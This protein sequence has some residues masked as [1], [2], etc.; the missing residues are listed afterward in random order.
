MQKAGLQ[1][2]RLGNQFAGLAGQ[3]AGVHPIVGNL[4]GVL[5]NF[6]V[7]AGLTVGVL[8]G[9]AAIALAYDALTKSA[10]EA[11]KAQDEAVKSLSEMLK[12]RAG[13]PSGGIAAQ[14][15]QAHAKEPRLMKREAELLR[16]LETNRGIPGLEQ[17]T[18]GKLEDVQLELEN[19]RNIIKAA[20]KVLASDIAKKDTE[21]LGAEQRK[22]AAAHAKVEAA[23][24]KQES[25]LI[26]YNN[27]MA[28]VYG[29]RSILEPE[30]TK[31]LRE[32]LQNE[33]NPLSLNNRANAIAFGKALE[34]SAKE[35]AVSGQFGGGFSMPSIGINDGL[36]KEQIKTRQKLGILI[37][38]EFVN[39]EKLKDAI[40]GSAAT[41][42]NTIVSALNIGGGGKGS[43]LGGAIGGTAG[44][45]VG[46]A[47]GGPVGGAIGSTIGNIG[48]SLI[49][50]LFDH[51]KAVEANTS[52]T[53]QLTAA[54]MMLNSPSGYKT[55]AGRFDATVIKELKRVVPSYNSRGGAVA[56]I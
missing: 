36:T 35:E 23:L 33:R 2:G 9:V 27:L 15:A 50:G 28:S 45:A 6:T 46:F 56:S 47:M 14:V 54:M 7:G 42:A 20:E 22:Q 29:D 13:G 53:R 38:E 26:A 51:K 37:D 30:T 8:A 52:A 34:A 48:G 44:F 5:G 32:R 41:L 55:A 3:I 16:E 21:T 49:G 40:W 25:D 1:T 12:T 19:L 39:S 17:L 4:A 43:N 10:R 24:R 11:T 18:R 31:A